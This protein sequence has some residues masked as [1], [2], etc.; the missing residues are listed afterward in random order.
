M[1]TRPIPRLPS[2][3]RAQAADRQT[4]LDGSPSRETS[5]ATDRGWPS[6]PR[7]ADAAARTIGSGW[8]SIGSIAL[9]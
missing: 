3:R 7:H 2:R 1:A 4:I 8:S 6:R 9:A 5:G